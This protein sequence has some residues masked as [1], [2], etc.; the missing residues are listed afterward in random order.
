MHESALCGVTAFA[1]IT[2]ARGNLRRKIVDRALDE[3][4]HLR[5]TLEGLIEFFFG[6]VILIVGYV[7]MALQ[8]GCRAM[9]DLVEVALV[10]KRKSTVRLLP[11]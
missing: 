3:P 6:D 1:A 11:R 9:G 8:L 2:A 5:G 7:E 10:L 4:R